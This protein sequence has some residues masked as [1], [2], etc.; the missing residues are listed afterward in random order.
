MS[1]ISDLQ[2]RHAVKA[3]DPTKKVSKENIDKIAAAIMLQEY[4]TLSP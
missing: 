4:L 1:L 3:Y 2:W